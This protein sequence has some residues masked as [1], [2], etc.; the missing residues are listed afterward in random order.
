MGLDMSA[1]SALSTQQGNTY[2]FYDLYG[3]ECESNDLSLAESLASSEPF[4]TIG[5]FCSNDSNDNY[6]NDKIKNIKSQINDI[7][8]G[9]EARKSDDDTRMQTRDNLRKQFA[10]FDNVENESTW[11]TAESSLK[12]SFYKLEDKLKNSDNDGLTHSLDRIRRQ[13]EK[14][15]AK[16]DVKSAKQLEGEISSLMLTILDDEHGVELYISILYNFNE[17]FNSQSWT[18][19]SKARSILDNAMREAVSNPDKNRMR[20]YVGQLY[21]LLP[22]TEK[23]GRD[24][25]LGV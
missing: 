20:N 13:M 5:T 18:N 6:D 4:T 11:P 3:D 17:D 8:K 7:K 12:D 23:E 19:S 21:G 2:T 24:D 22:R 1:L 14:V 16:K 15:I 25:I 9:Y 10:E